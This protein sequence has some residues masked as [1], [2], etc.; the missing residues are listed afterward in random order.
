MCQERV[1]KDRLYLGSVRV[2]LYLLPRVVA[3]LRCVGLTCRP[4]ITRGCLIDK[5]MMRADLHGAISKKSLDRPCR[6]PAIELTTS[7]SYSNEKSR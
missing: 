5:K 6:C 2:L 3:R 1:S 7:T 4:I